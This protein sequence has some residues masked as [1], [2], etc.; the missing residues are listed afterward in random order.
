MYI[1]FR[2]T[3]WAYKSNLN[4]YIKHAAQPAYAETDFRPI[5]EDYFIKVKSLDIRYVMKRRLPGGRGSRPRQSTP[6]Q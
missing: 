3:S 4:T 6:A 2:L 1:F 5:D